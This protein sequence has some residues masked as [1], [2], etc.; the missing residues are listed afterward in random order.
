MVPSLLTFLFV[1]LDP[2][3][4]HLA[5][6]VLFGELVGVEGVADKLVLSGAVQNLLVPFL[7][8]GR[9]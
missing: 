3:L 2:E 5:A 9:V 6:D 7:R 8:R 4:L 1:V